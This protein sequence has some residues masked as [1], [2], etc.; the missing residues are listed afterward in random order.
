[1]KIYIPATPAP[2]DLRH[3]TDNLDERLSIF[4]GDTIPD[5][6]H[7]LVT[8]RP[9]EA[10]LQASPCL[11]TLLIPFAGLPTVTREQMR[12]YP[13]ITIY[14]LHHNK[15]TTGEMAL[16]LLFACARQLIPAHNRF[17]QHDWTPRY[18]PLQQVILYQKTVLIL[19][20]GSIGQYIA[21]VL[22]ALGM[23]VLGIR[24]TQSDSDNGI[25]TLDSLHD[26]LPKAD[27]LMVT[28]PATDETTGLLGET[29]FDLLPDNAI[30]VNVGRAGVIDQQA[31]YDALKSGKLHA[32]ASD[33]WYHYPS[34]NLEPPFDDKNMTVAPADVP[35]HEL[36][37][38]V[39]SPHRAGAFGN[40]DVE[41]MRYTRMAEL[42]NQLAK[43]E[44]LPNR[45][46]LDRGY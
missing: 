1:M 30:V 34:G 14:N 46:D 17:R 31:F 33:V 41:R 23:N 18:A 37:N 8:G 12:D 35:F 44:H 19:G 39:M 7:V 32:G 28:I 5:E 25:Y 9:S 42:M 10:Q 2:E 21:P 26:L 6:Y 15:V 13:N 3:L 45:V 24:R 29:E 20:Y 11:H 38:M 16:S 4:T 36:D 27:V 22:K 40:A 43:G